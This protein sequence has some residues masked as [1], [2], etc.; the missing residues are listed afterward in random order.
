MTRLE[1]DPIVVLVHPDGSLVSAEPALQNLGL[2]LLTCSL[3]TE[4]ALWT[5][6]QQSGQTEW[7]CGSKALR[8]DIKA[9]IGYSIVSAGCWCL[10]N[11]ATL[12]S[13]ACQAS[14]LMR[15]QNR[16]VRHA[17]KTEAFRTS[18][19]PFSPCGRL[20][21]QIHDNVRYDE[22]ARDTS[23]AMACP[24][25]NARR[26]CRIQGPR[27][28]VESSATDLGHAGCLRQ[29]LATWTNEPLCHRA[30]NT[31]M[32]QLRHGSHISQ[33]RDS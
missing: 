3:G 25:T 32:L 10:V 16:P 6:V 1:H 9:E 12:P 13:S 28:L 20:G 33:A 23:G 5:S 26:A 29:H 31:R 14:R 22:T 27:K 18:A 15:L 7:S 24:L 19:T 17:G 11:Q 4:R 8:P 21:L 30:C 2:V